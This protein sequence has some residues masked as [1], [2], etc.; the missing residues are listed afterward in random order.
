MPSADVNR[1]DCM[2]SLRSERLL[3]S[4]SYIPVGFLLQL[5][6]QLLPR[7]L[8]R[9]FIPPRREAVHGVLLVFLQERLQLGRID[10]V[11]GVVVHSS[12]PRER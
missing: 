8:L 10:N 6:P 2:I 1:R 3:L 7:V 5:M 4:S 11:F 9:G 12:L